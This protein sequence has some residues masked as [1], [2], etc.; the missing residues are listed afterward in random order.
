MPELVDLEAVKNFLT[1]R[2]VGQPVRGV[3]VSRKG[4]IKAGRADG[5]VGQRVEALDRRGKCLIF[6]ISHGLYLVVHL[7][8]WAWLWYGP[9]S[10][11]PTGSTDLRLSLGNG[12]D[13]RLI[14]PTPVKLA[15]VWVVDKLES[16]EPL[17]GL[18]VEPLSEEFTWERFRALVGGKRRVLKRLLVDQS[19][20]AGLG[21]AFADEILFQARLS[22]VRHA[23]TLSEEE[24][25]RLWAAIP[26]TLRWGIAEVEARMG[27]HLFE[28]E[29][30]D[31]LYVHG[32]VGEP[33]RVCGTPIEEFLLEG[34]RTNYCRTCQNV[35]RL[36]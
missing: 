9:T 17:Q 20:I 27:E 26:K 1:P 13:V 36:R 31:F 25:Q 8:R 2:I 16:A 3:E 5:L 19:L 12:H 28:K 11:A 15:Q 35:N 33:C 7:M 6:S 21:N 18:G 29:I 30:R 24:L 10:Y 4:L 32:R 34:Q 14:E 22:P 23:H